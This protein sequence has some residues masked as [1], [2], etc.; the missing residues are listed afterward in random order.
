ME[1]DK[2]IEELWHEIDAKTMVASKED[3][4]TIL[5]AIEDEQLVYAENM[6]RELLK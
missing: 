4:R 3:L 5:W 6:L 2:F 1:Y